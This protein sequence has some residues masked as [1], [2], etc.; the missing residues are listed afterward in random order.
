VTAPPQPAERV[1]ETERL[2]V[3]DWTH[4]DAERLLDTYS[5]PDVVR[6]LGS[7]P[8]LMDSLDTAHERIDRALARSAEDRAAG[9]PTGWWAVER[10]DTG[11]VAGTVALVTVDGSRD[12]AAQVEVAWTLHPDSQGNGYATEAARA[13]LA[14]G[15]AAGISEVLALTDPANLP[16][17]AVCR[18]L[19]LVLTGTS[20]AYYGKPLLV[21]VSRAAD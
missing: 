6:F 21:W 11:V 13:V 17:Q 9:L 18:R 10:K 3:R 15:H 4:D 19:D 8:R 2:V 14:R 20:E 7:A 1:L 16:S 12:P 5:R